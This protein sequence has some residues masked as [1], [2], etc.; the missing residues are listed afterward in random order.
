MLGSL[1]EELMH[2]TDSVGAFVLWND[3]RE[4]YIDDNALGLLGMDREYLSCDA[5]RNVL[6]CALD[7]EVSSSPAKV[8]TVHVDDED[9][10][11]GFVVRR[12]TAVPL[13]IGEM[14]PLLN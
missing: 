7:A 13:A 2:C 9:C 6:E 12:D 11:A 5:L 10:I 4:Y 14:Y 3:S 1:W 8:M